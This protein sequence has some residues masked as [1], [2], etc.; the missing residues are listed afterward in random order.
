MRSKSFSSAL[1]LVLAFLVGAAPALGDKK[2]FKTTAQG[3]PK[4]KSIDAISFAPD[5]VLLIGDG[6][7]SQIVAID[8]KDTTPQKWTKAE[9]ANIKDELAGRLGTTG[10]AIE[11][12]KMAVNP[13]SQTAYFAVRNLDSKK[14]LILTLSGSGKVGELDLESVTYARVELPKGDEGAISKITDVAWAGDSILAAA[15][16]AGKFASKVYSI[17]APLDT[18]TK[19]G[20]CGTETY[21]VAHGRWETHAPLQTILPYEENGKKYI[22][23]AFTC[24]PLVKFPLEDVKSGVK[25]KGTSVIEVGNGNEPRDMF[26]YEKNG[27]TYILMS[28][29]RMFH[30]KSPMGPSPY[31][32][33]RLEY[34]LLKESDKINEKALRRLDKKGQPAT[35]RAMVAKDFHGVVHMDKLDNQRAI[36]VRTDDK[37]GFSLAVINLP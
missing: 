15:K 25:I 35:D 18:E 26:T 16:T 3:D 14:N 8:T 22:V 20:I 31:W 7:G 17:P 34:D 24:T 27:K 36:A 19:A 28:T 33:V 21:H 10:K 30:A 4:I 12:L 29:Y 23:G 6:R 9:V 11:I 2:V 32:T 13:A 5:G 37:G 1:G